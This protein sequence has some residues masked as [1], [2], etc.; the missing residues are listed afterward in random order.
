M[1]LCASKP[2]TVAE[3]VKNPAGP[4]GQGRGKKGLARQKSSQENKVQEILSKAKKHRKVI[5]DASSLDPDFVCP[6]FEKSDDV[7]KMITNV[8]MNKF[9]MF[10]TFT[11]EQREE[12]VMAMEKCET[13]D[14]GSELIKQGDVGDF[15]YILESGKVDVHVDGMGQVASLGPESLFGELA[16]IYD[17]PRAATVTVVGECTLWKVSRKVLQHVAARGETDRVSSCMEC[18][19]KVKIL[20]GADESLLKRLAEALEPVNFNKGDKIIEQGTTGDVFYLLREGRVNCVDN[21]SDNEDVELSSGAYFGELALL[22]DK[23]RQR[24]V[25]AVSEKCVCYSLGRADFL[26]IFGSSLQEVMEKDLGFRVLRSM[27]QLK[28][29]PNSE[30]IAMANELETRAF[31]VDAKIIEEKKAG[32]TCFI[33]LSGLVTVSVKGK[34]VVDLRSGRFFGEKALLEDAPRNAT[35][36]ANQKGTKCFVLSREQFNRHTANVK[37]E[38]NA[39]N[40]KRKAMLRGQEPPLLENLQEH[41]LLG[42][43]TFGRVFLV[44]DKTAD[45]MGEKVTWALKT[46]KK[47]QVVQY[48]LE[49]NVVYEAAMMKQCNH[50]FVLSLVQTYM[51]TD[52]LYMLLEFVQGGELFSLLDKYKRLNFGHARLYAACVLDAFIYIHGK[53]IIYRDLKP[54]NLLIDKDGYIRVVDFGFAKHISRTGKTFTLCGTPEYLAP[55]I[56]LRKGH[57]YGVDYWG[58]GIL[59]WEMLTGETPFQDQSGNLDDRVI[60][61]NII[62]SSLNFPREIDKK[63]RLLIVKLLQKNPAKRLGCLSNGGDDIKNDNY[64]AGFDWE[65][66]AAKEMQTPWKPVIKDSMD[67]SNFDEFDE[68]DDPSV[69]KTFRDP[70]QGNKYH[71]SQGWCKDF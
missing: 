39:L 61:S 12:F 52:M 69:G 28:A 8:L 29:L 60:C 5:Q 35:V 38:L 71:G 41:Q 7:K 22:N 54:E 56:V 62:R 45:Q 3:P 58:I 57:N 48:K 15:M 18:L 44:T 50:P 65:K 70:G 21:K 51:D 68:E 20:K 30:I 66:M 36:T 37:E 10:E 59:I 46:M 9:F 43:G 63:S 4:S 55:E 14:G 47:K 53:E 34:K 49:R 24:D 31:E 17:A 25:I 32:D 40:E 27:P 23:P 13:S 2:D 33:L 42:T 11:T 19:Q 67:V 64:F 1:G 26:S 6:S 16:L